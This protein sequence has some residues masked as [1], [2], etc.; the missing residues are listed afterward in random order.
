MTPPVRH[1]FHGLAAILAAA[2]ALCLA[3]AARTFLSGGPA[4]AAAPAADTPAAPVAAPADPL[5]GLA[6][7]LAPAAPADPGALARRFRL[8]GVVRG[9]APM[10]ILDDRVAVRQSIATLRA[11]VAPGIVLTDVRD[12]GVTL[13]GPDGEE[14]LA[15]ERAAPRAVAASAAPAAAAPDAPPPEPGS[16]AAAAARFGGYEDFPGRWVYDRRKVLDYYEELR[17]EPERLLQ[18]FDSMDPVWVEDADGERRIE[19]YRVGV[20]GEAELFA[21]AGLK[22]GDVVK[23]VNDLAMTRRDRAERMIAAFIEGRGTMFVL[24]IE[25]DGRTFKQVID[26]EDAE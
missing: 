25:R 12:D 19:G 14:D 4:Q 2:A 10:A 17:A 16:R 20:E 8:A 13:A 15:I 7:V 23:S 21:A 18:V 9:A 22:D 24:E 5:A 3:F 26:F 1:L 6:D 11:E